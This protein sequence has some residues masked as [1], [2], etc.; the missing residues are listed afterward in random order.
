MTA[1]GL[2]QL[3]GRRALV[4]GGG[5][6]IGGALAD[7]LAGAGAHVAVLGRSAT[8]DAAAARV[9]GIAVRAD[10]SDRADLARGFEPGN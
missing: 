2:F 8:A 7:A 10:L 5:G 1:P 3:A 6:V 9:D 4:T